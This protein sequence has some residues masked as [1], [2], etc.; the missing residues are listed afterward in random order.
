MTREMAHLCSSSPQ[1]NFLRAP[2]TG[3]LNV[4]VC[5]AR[6]GLRRSEEHSNVARGAGREFLVACVCFF[7][8]ANI[9][10]LH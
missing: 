8:V 10:S 2:A 5:N 7:E 3:A 1:G 6:T 4:D 9:H